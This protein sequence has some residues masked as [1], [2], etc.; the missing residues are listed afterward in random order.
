MIMSRPS[1]TLS[2]I[3]I[4]AALALVTTSTLAVH[5]FA[6]KRFYNCMTDV[7]NKHGQLTIDDVNLCYD[8][9]YHTGSFSA[10]SHSAAGAG[11]TSTDSSG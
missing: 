8:K 1:T 6:I 10:H 11:G 2:I 4:V 5:A 9:E 7:A 3:G